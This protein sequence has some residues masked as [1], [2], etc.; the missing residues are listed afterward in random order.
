MSSLQI[1]PQ[2]YPPRPYGVQV[3]QRGPHGR[4]LADGPQRGPDGKIRW[5]HEQMAD[6]GQLATWWRPE[7]QVV[8]L[9]GLGG[10][11]DDVT[12]WISDKIVGAGLVDAR[13]GNTAGRKFDSGANQTVGTLTP[14]DKA[15]RTQAVLAFEQEVNR[16]PPRYNAEQLRTMAGTLRNMLA[17]S[18]WTDSGSSPRYL[19]QPKLLEILGSAQNRAIQRSGVREDGAP[20][21]SS[22]AVGPDGREQWNSPRQ[23]ARDS[24]RESAE[25]VAWSGQKLV[26][27]ALA[28]GAAAIVLNG[29]AKGYG[30]GLARRRPKK[31]P[32]RRRK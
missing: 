29:F 20:M 3:I 13:G 6:K 11:Y 22:T 14:S 8:G 17:S 7:Q 5:W 2:V 19:P 23:A 32:R 30:S 4:M 12:S 10:V 28:V 15:A 26:G 25:S 24:L 21:F 18:R 27:V 16:T 31:N 1:G 9:L